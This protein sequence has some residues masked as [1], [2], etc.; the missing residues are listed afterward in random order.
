MADEIR[1]EHEFRHPPERVFAAWTSAEQLA[2]WMCP[3]DGTVIEAVADPRVGGEFRV[4][5]DVGEASPILHEGHYV[6][7]D[8]P[9]FLEV[10]WRSVNT[11]GRDTLVS[12]SIDPVANGARLVLVHRSVP[13]AAM[14]GHRIGWESILARLD[15]VLSVGER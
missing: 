11:G 12:V 10:T 14:E 6:T 3:G 13:P 9:R 4:L 7:V 5:M 8:P 2:T 15:G 1:V